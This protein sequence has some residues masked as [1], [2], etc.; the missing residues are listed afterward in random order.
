M[1]RG[2]RQNMVG[3]ADLFLAKWWRHMLQVKLGNRRCGVGGYQKRTKHNSSPHALLGNG[4]KHSSRC[5]GIGIRLLRLR[6][7][8]R[9][10][11]APIYAAKDLE[12]LSVIVLLVLSIC[13]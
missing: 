9:S 11:N 1:S 5:Y 2:P 7:T 6:A 8:K 4:M 13:V 3:L 12:Y 10:K